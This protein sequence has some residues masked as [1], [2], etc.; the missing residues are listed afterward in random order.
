MQSCRARSNGC[1]LER[2]FE[3]ARRTLADGADVLCS[4]AKCGARAAQNSFPPGFLWGSAT[5]GHQIEGNDTNSDFWLLENIKPTLFA[6]SVGDACDSYHRWADD[7]DLVRAIGLNSYRFS[8]E[9]SR[10]EPSC[11]WLFF[12][13]AFWGQLKFSKK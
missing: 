12:L 9:W 8:L 5:A 4:V 10:I 3:A 7:L 13:V 11:R 2:P 6:E 1:S